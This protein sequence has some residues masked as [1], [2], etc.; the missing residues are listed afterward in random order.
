MDKQTPF[1]AL[2]GTT[3]QFAPHS[4]T[5]VAV[6]G[7]S[8]LV[9]RHDTGFAVFLNRCPHQ[10]R[11]MLAPEWKDGAIVCDHHSVGFDSSSGEVCRDRGFLG[12]CGLQRLG[13]EEREGS[14]F[15]TAP[16]A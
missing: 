6:A 11:E 13:H 3:E 2:L 9:S 10:E 1:P 15:L 12:L 14:L 16:G 5:A 7:V 8:C 4:V